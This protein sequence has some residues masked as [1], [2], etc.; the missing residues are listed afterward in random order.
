MSM[1]MTMSMEGEGTY[2]SHTSMYLEVVLGSS[3]INS[4]SQLAAKKAGALKIKQSD[5]KDITIFVKALILHE[6]KQ[7]RPQLLNQY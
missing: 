5:V 6:A 2:V 7:H 1:F 4:N 3:E